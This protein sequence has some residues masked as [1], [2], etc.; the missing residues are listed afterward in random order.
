[1]C[2]AVLVNVAVGGGVL[3]FETVSVLVNV[4]VA[5]GVIVLLSVM[6][7]E[8]VIGRDFVKGA[9]SVAF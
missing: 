9:V 1:M 5:G 8:G 3:V 2:V 4:A 6:L 7:F